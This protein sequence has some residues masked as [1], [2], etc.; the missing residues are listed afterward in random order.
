MIFDGRRD[1]A[2][3]LGDLDSI[4][5]DRRL[6]QHDRVDVLVG[7]PDRG[8]VRGLHRRE[9]HVACLIGRP[10]GV[11]VEGDRPAALGARGDLLAPG[12]ELL[13]HQRIDHRHLTDLRQGGQR[14]EVEE[15]IELRD[16]ARGGRGDFQAQRAVDRELAR[17]EGLRDLDLIRRTRRGL[18][19][20]DLEQRLGG[21]GRN[22]HGTAEV[23]ETEF[24]LHRRDLVDAGVLGA[25]Q[26]I[27]EGR[28]FPAGAGGRTRLHVRRGEGDRA[29]VKEGGEAFG[30][31]L[32]EFIA[33]TLRLRTF[34][35]LLASA[36][37]RGGE[38]RGIVAEILA[39]AGHAT[40]G[41]GV[42]DADDEAE[43]LVG[44]DGVGAVD[45]RL[46][47]DLAEQLVEVVGALLQAEGE[48]IVLRHDQGAGE[49]AVLEILVHR[50]VGVV[51]AAVERLGQLAH[52]GGRQ[53][54]RQRQDS[55][56][57]PAQGGAVH[58]LAEIDLAGAADAE[59][60]VEPAQIG[61]DGILIGRQTD[62][63]T[64]VGVGGAL[65]IVLRPERF[66][67]RKHETSGGL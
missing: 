10:D 3:A 6:R 13:H 66:F 29:D 48:R 20:G 26:H 40:H 33:R 47:A 55:G 15:V 53:L 18:A 14:R 51:Q 7:A 67:L 43:L 28:L 21:S 60:G 5:Q 41:L 27:G 30:E 38:G 22:R 24:H 36:L 37:G 56:A 11:A 1:V 50:V 12:I 17:V 65:E 39:E 54:A 52:V 61:F 8:R 4:Q 58:R 19:A 57:D 45:P 23:D 25:D 16:E 31:L 2:R 32:L 42:H 46:D 44:A 34:G 63:L 35:R 9:R 62:D 59:D 64:A 49:I